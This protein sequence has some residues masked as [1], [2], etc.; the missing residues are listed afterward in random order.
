MFIPDPEFYPFRIS[1]PGSQIKKQQQETRGKNYL[2][3]IQNFIHSGSRIP[4]PR[5]KNSNKRRGGK[6]IYPVS[7]ILSIPDLGFRIPDQKTATRDS[8]EK[9]S[10]F[11]VTTNITKLKLFYL[12]NR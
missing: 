6:I 8:G 4:D 1:D 10:N 7:R 12:L 5:S 9:L 2:S 3:R 11:V